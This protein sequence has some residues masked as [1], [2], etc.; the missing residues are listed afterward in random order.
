LAAI[1]K[2]MHIPHLRHVHIYA[3]ERNVRPDHIANFSLRRMV[4][5]RPRAIGDPMR[6]ESDALFTSLLPERV[7]VDGPFRKE[8]PARKGIFGRSN[9][10][11]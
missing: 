3:F 2:I 10:V 4:P 1:L 5:C 6:V 9:P 8:I 11:I 7:F